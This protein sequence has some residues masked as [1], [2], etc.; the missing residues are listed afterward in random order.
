MKNK[1]IVRC[2]VAMTRNIVAIVKYK[3]TIASTSNSYEEKIVG[4]KML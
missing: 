4:K 3:V 2:K 1:V